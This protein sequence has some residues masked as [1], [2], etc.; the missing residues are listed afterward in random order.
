MKKITSTLVSVALGCCIASNATHASIIQGM[1]IEEIGIASSGLGTSAA[2]L[3]G[4]RFTFTAAPTAF[5][6][7]TSG[8]GTDGAILMGLVQNDSAFTP[9]F[10][11]LG[12][13]VFPNTL[14]GAPSGEVGGGTNLILN[15][16]GWG[17][18]VSSGLGYF[19]TPP[20]FGTLITSLLVKDATSYFYTADWSRQITASDDPSGAF[21]G[22][23]S[24]W[25]LEGIAT[26]AVPEP[27]TAWLVGAALIGLVGTRRKKQV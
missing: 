8:G 24:F 1:T 10:L 26:T 2:F 13:N 12:L 14:A 9:G 5:A 27:G 25:H 15:L 20:E 23:T 6:D 3:G 7:F 16:S 21:I 18:N 11:F 22:F 17:I 4:G 19:P